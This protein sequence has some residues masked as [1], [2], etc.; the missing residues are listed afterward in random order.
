MLWDSTDTLPKAKTIK[1]FFLFYYPLHLHWNF[2]DFNFAGVVYKFQFGLCNE[3]CYRERVRHLAVR[4]GEHTSIS[5][6]TI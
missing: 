1:L 5:P 3:P 4:S 2:E 6:L